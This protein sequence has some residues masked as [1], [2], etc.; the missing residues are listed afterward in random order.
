MDML[1]ILHVCCRMG[2]FGSSSVFYNVVCIC[3][4]SCTQHNNWM[5]KRLKSSS[6]FT[7]KYCVA[8]RIVYKY[9]QQYK[10]QKKTQ[11]RPFYSIYVKFVTYPWEFL[12]RLKKSTYNNNSEISLLLWN[13][14]LGFIYFMCYSVLAP[15]II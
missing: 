12:Y 2:V 9:R 3:I 7:F 8:H 10:K 5:L 14:N 11:T 6:F 15:S 13:S 1:Q 4:L